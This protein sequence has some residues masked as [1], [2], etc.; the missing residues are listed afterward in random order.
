M[1]N[2]GGFLSS[3]ITRFLFIFIPAAGMVVL[4]SWGIYYLQYIKTHQDVLRAQEAY[5]QDIKAEY[6]KLRLSTIISDL[7]VIAYH[8]QI[9]DLIQGGRDG[10]A[11]KQELLDLSRY[12]GIYDQIRVL[13]NRGQELVRVDLCGSR[14]ILVPPA[15][16][17][18]KG[19]RYYV[20]DIQNLSRGEVYM[21]RLD[22]N[23]EHGLVE[24][25]LKPVIRFGIPL[26]NEQGVRRGSL[27]LNYLGNDLISALQELSFDSPGRL[28]LLN[29]DG[30]W[31]K[32]LSPDDEWGFMIDSRAE[33]N[34]SRRFPKIWKRMLRADH[35]QFLTSEGLV[36]F[37]KIYPLKP[38]IV[39]IQGK[40][41]SSDGSVSEAGHSRYLRPDELF[42]VIV[43]LVP[44][45]K[46]YTGGN[47]LVYML[48]LVDTLLLM[49][50]GGISWKLIDANEKR[51]QA[52]RS[53]RIWNN[54]LEEKIQDRTKALSDVNDALRNEIE[55]HHRSVEEK[56]KIESQLRQAQ[57]ME[58][59]GT[60]AG[61]VAHDFNNILTPINGYAEIVLMRLKEDDPLRGT[62]GEILKA[63][64]RAKDLVAQILAFSRQTEYE[65]APVKIQTIVKETIKFLRASIPVT[66]EIKSD[67]DSDCR[68]V[69]ADPTQIHQVIMNLC[70]NAYHAMLEEGGV[71]TI[72]LRELDIGTEDYRT[73]FQLSPGSYLKLEISDTGSGMSREVQEKIFEP[74]FTTKESGKGTGLGLSLVHAIIR[75]LNGH[76]AVYSEPGEGSTFR[77]YLPVIESEE[78]G[79]ETA[80]VDMLPCGTERLLIVDDEDSI[81]EVEKQMLEPLGYQVT[82]TTGSFEALRLFEQNPAGFDLVVTD[83]TMPGLTGIE[84]I[85]KLRQSRFDIP[86]VLCT[87]YSEI[88]NVEQARSHGIEECI[89]KP[90]TVAVLAKAVRSALDRRC[91]S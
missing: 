26:F 68:A 34:M 2:S 27:F 36:T 20:R 87:G 40:V 23:V 81:T 53:L 90:I 30:Y 31:L 7:H 17:Q 25:P 55:E 45:E 4:A 75:N 83:M 15:E 19:Q 42:W 56:N 18:F 77:I 85:E 67:I 28:M 52:E 59:I 86:V 88:I 9:L 58:A 44:P 89:S 39:S 51:R 84:L 54:E 14:P 6:I 8:R 43:S 16:L 70:T 5:S 10:E 71:M 13:D 35:G 3:R 69:M 82:T 64:R 24:V 29:R 49:L 73:G 65:L 66:I 63:A 57:K 32:G 47:G 76:I 74:Y 41:L 62:M 91:S 21:S 33:Q 37:S 11:F 12:K 22:L 79:E 80:S 1:K 50:L 60:L 61:G 72:V 38:G 78:P 48:I 46:M